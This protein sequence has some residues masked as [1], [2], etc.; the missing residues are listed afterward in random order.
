MAPDH[1]RRLV[2]VFSFLALLVNVGCVSVKPP[3]GFLR[4]RQDTAQMK[5]VSDDESLFW[6]REF[7]DSERAGFD[8][9]ASALR[10]DFIDQR[11]YTLLE[12]R[13]LQAFG[14]PGLEMLFEVT[15][16]GVARRYLLCMSVDEGIFAD[17]IRVAEY[18]ADKARFDRHLESVRRVLDGRQ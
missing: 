6:Y 17:E 14:E 1:S 7:R 10:H 5:A 11:G 2:F 18:V 8:F 16:D 4:V 13:E 12:E 9:W 3:D 15:V